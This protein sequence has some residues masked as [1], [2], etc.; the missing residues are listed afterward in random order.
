M[1]KIER[2]TN[3]W[4]V[5]HTCEDEPEDVYVFNADD[6]DESEAKAFAH[7]LQVVKNLCGPQ[8]S[9]YSAHRVMI[10]IQ[11]GDKH[12]SHSDNQD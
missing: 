3:G 11:P 6:G 4:I 1:I 10:T 5:R 12:R 7:L 9:R 8:E 2:A